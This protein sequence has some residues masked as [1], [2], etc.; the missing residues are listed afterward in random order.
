MILSLK[1]IDFDKLLEL[2][3]D[4]AKD[5]VRL[6]PKSNPKNPRH[7]PTPNPK[8]NPTP[9]PDNPTPNVMMGSMGSIRHCDSWCFKHWKCAHIKGASEGGVND[10]VSQCKFLHDPAMEDT[11]PKDRIAFFNTIPCKH[12]SEKDCPFMARPGGCHFKHS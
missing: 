11:D 6:K 3:K 1:Q 4:C 10:G 9:K 7:N 12:G 8:H 2:A 5:W